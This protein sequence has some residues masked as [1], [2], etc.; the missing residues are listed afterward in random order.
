[1]DDVGCDLPHAF[2]G[3]LKTDCRGGLVRMKGPG[4]RPIL[5]SRKSAA[6]ALGS[7]GSGGLPQWSPRC[8]ST[9]G[10]LRNGAM[11]GRKRVWCSV[12]QCGAA[13]SVKLVV[14]EKARSLARELSG[15]LDAA[16]GRLQRAVQERRAV[17]RAVR[18]GERR[19]VRRAR[20]GEVLELAVSSAAGE[21]ES[22]GG[23]S[24][25]ANHEGVAL[26]S[27]SGISSPQWSPRCASTAGL[28]R[29]GVMPVGGGVWCSVA[30]RVRP[31]FAQHRVRRGGQ[32]WAGCG[33]CKVQLR[34]PSSDK[35]GGCRLGLHFAGRG[36][37]GVLSGS[38]RKGA[39][40]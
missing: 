36:L 28:L 12:A 5:V 15:S 17:R 25:L 37:G 8:A 19:A 7:S 14:L 26:S 2:L 11:R 27:S 33:A 22:L 13:E 40:A 1:M 20:A 10:L 6:F 4:G 18:R 3:S 34:S 23:G 39:K 30:R 21:G 38:A 16:G 31:R 9:A 32:R 24:S 29:H 35:G